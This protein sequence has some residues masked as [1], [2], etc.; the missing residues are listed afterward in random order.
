MKGHKTF[1]STESKLV[2]VTDFG[3][4]SVQTLNH[5]ATMKMDSKDFGF[6]LF[7]LVSKQ[8]VVVDV[9]NIGDSPYFGVY[10]TRGKSA[11]FSVEGL[12]KDPK[13][14]MWLKAGDKVVGVYNVPME[15]EKPESHKHKLLKE[16]LQREK[17]QIHKQID[18]RIDSLI[19]G[20]V[21]V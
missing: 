15:E 4:V 21:D 6:D 3:Y 1:I 9:V 20:D 17:K 14:I 19:G 8:G 13:K 7:K 5:K 10:T 11:I 2:S 12:T 16:Q 18:E